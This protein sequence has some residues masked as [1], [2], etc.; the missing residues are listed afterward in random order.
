[1]LDH[2]QTHPLRE[3]VQLST[4]GSVSVFGGDGRGCGESGPLKR[5]QEEENVAWV[6]GVGVEA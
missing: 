6:M 4:A 2:V 1:M 5:G 3:G